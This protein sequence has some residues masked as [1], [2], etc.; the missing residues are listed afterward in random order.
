VLIMEQLLI[1]EQIDLATF[2]D[3][4]PGACSANYITVLEV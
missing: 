4:F 1:M 3:S 2:A